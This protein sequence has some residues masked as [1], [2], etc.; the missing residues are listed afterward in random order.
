MTFFTVYIYTEMAGFFLVIYGHQSVCTAQFLT[1]CSAFNADVVN[2][3]KNA[4]QSAMDIAK[5]QMQPTHPIRLGLALN[6]SVF[7]YEIQNAPDQACQLAKQVHY[8]FSLQ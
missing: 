5:D 7:F 2:E 4:Y 1:S 3:S 8:H 6:F